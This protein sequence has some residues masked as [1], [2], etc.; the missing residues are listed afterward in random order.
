M[1]VSAETLR[2]AAEPCVAVDG[3]ALLGE[4]GR[5]ESEDEPDG[6]QRAHE[7]S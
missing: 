4:R 6:G 3:A 7:A 2:G 1:G 5:G